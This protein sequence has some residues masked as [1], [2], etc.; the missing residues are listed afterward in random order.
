MASNTLDLYA[1]EV[2]DAKEET[3]SLNVRMTKQM[4]DDFTKHCESRGVEVAKVIRRF[5]ER[6]LTAK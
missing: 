6:E 5:I 4:R 3:V 1:P 2:K